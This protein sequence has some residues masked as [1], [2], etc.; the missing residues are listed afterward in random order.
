MQKMSLWRGYTI[1]LMVLL[2][3]TALTILTATLTDGLRF[4]KTQP[5]AKPVK[6]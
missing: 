3:L 5:H 1:L 6:H 2:L 4:T